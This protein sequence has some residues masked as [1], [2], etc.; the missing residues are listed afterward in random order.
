MQ[1]ACGKLARAAALASLLLVAWPAAAQDVYLGFGFGQARADFDTLG[2]TLADDREST[3]IKLFA[4]YRLTRLLALE[5]FYADLRQ[6]SATVQTGTGTLSTS[7]EADGFGAAV[8]LGLPLGE[9]AELYAKGGVFRWDL[10]S[11]TARENDVGPM[12]GLGL[13]LWGPAPSASVRIE[14]ERFKDV[15]AEAFAGTN[16]GIDIDL[17]TLGI[18]YNF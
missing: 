9:K 6:Y 10:V 8:T 17:L 3:A 13:H 18:I 1:Q 15:G 11:S 2:D 14:Y 7:A 5:A 12:F 16:D 4:G